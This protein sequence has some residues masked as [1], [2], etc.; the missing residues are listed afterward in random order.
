M[1]SIDN[2]LQIMTDSLIKKGEYLDRILTKNKAQYECIKGK[3][4]EDVDW[5]AFNVLVTEKEASIN[6]IMEIDEGFAS[7]YEKIK[8][9][10]ISNKDKYRDK[11]A[12][13]QEIITVLT[14]DIVIQRVV[15]GDD[16]VTLRNDGADRDLTGWYLYSDRGSELYA[17][18]DGYILG[19]G[20]TVTV[21]TNSSDDGDYDLLW[22]DKKVIHKTKEDMILLY[23]SYGRSIDA[24][25]NGN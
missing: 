14:S 4:Y 24:M 2:Y 19:A 16:L 13:L 17:F 23:D 20:K 12:E 6:R 10:V 21:G 18:P 25:S 3:E 9:E 5:A 7:I 15:P 1:E 8:D 11:V 22:D